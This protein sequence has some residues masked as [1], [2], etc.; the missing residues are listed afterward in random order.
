MGDGNNAWPIQALVKTKLSKLA[1]P[2]SMKQNILKS[3]VGLC[4]LFTHSFQDGFIGT[5]AIASQKDMDK[6]SY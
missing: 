2:F 6:I 4:D 5:G 3:F 1:V